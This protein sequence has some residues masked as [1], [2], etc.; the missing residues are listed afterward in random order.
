[1]TDLSGKQGMKMGY[2]ERKWD[3]DENLGHG[4][5]LDGAL[6]ANVNLYKDI[7]WGI[8]NIIGHK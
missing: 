6:D 2:L 3:V 7:S 8:N 4:A 5:F 1:M